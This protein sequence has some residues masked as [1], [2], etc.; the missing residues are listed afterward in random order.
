M[1]W[2]LVTLGAVGRSKDADVLIF[3]SWDCDAVSAGAIAVRPDMG[4][5]YRS[6]M[7]Q[8]VSN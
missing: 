8:F 1:D 2:A 6:M 7:L 5:S 3:G 4:C